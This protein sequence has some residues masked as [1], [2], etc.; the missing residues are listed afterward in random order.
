MPLVLNLPAALHNN[1]LVSYA[2][3]QDLCL[4]TSPTPPQ[5][6]ETK[7]V[8]EEET[9]RGQ[10]EVARKKLPYSILEELKSQW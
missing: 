6:I 2:T 10:M 7:R 3:D 4:I 1:L 9:K 8:I 5:L